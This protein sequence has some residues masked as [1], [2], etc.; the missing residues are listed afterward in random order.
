MST[1]ARKAKTSD[2]PWEVARL[3][4]IFF[5]V[6]SPRE[7][8]QDWFRDLT[9]EKPEQTLAQQA[10]AVSVGPYRGAMFNLT[11]D[12]LRIVFTLHPKPDKEKPNA[13]ATLE[14]TPADS[15]K[16]LIA[17]V[18]RWIDRNRQMPIKRIG[19][20]GLLM[21]RTKDQRSGYGILK[22][23]LPTVTF[24][25]KCTDLLFRINRPRELKSIKGQT[26]NRMSTWSLL[27]LAKMAQAITPVAPPVTSSRELEFACALEFDVNTAQDFAGELPHQKLKR[28]LNELVEASLEIA[29]KGDFR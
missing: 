26:L 3:Q 23:Y 6:Q 11:I 5:P 15:C 13:F 21:Q 22:N 18:G 10:E 1:K 29:R 9:G 4:A 17:L 14:E 20:A 28:V 16:A 24:S 12:L 25:P 27:G 7:I 19:F 2:V 8:S